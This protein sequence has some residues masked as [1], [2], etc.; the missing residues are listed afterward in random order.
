MNEQI[1]FIVIIPVY[2]MAAWIGENIALL[3]N[4]T[5]SNFRCLLGDDLSTDN[6]VAV[7]EGAIGDDKRFKL[8]TH[9]TKK[10]SLGNICTLIEAAKADDNDVIVLIDG[11]DRLANE[12]VLQT[13]AD[14]YRQNDC[15]MTYGSYAAEGRGPEAICR[16]YPRKI[17]MLNAFRY[18]KWRA[19]HLKTFKY[20][21][22]RHVK[23][24]SLTIS[25]RE[26]RRARL[27][28]LFT[29]CWR[30]WFHWRHIQLNELLDETRQFTRRCS[31]KVIT[32]PLLEMAGEKA[33]FIPDILYYYRAYEKDLQFNTA[34][35]R[36]KWYQRLTRNI[37]RHKT[38]YQKLAQL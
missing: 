1:R 2:N 32:S 20:G 28:A 36:Q 3:K 11:D 26:L 21:L 29:G 35:S 38:R 5:Y 37:V 34:K 15:W 6:S 22:W 9:R 23:P 30:T 16:P 10:Y 18:V 14:V 25:S 17:V 13:L 4:Q 8:V 7:I 24:S 27:R 31:D 12:N 19:S 33:V